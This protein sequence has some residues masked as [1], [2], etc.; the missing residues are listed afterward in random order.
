MTKLDELKACYPEATTFKFG[1]SPDLSDCLLSLV[2]SGKK[3]AT[4]EV[5]A[6]FESGKAAMPQVG[7]HDIAL[8]WDDRPALVIRT[9]SLERRRFCDVPESFALAEGESDSLEAWRRDHEEYFTRNGG[10]DPNMLL[11]CERFEL[12]EDLA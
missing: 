2:R 5:L 7:R 11:I 3:T 1:D 4:C 8:E 6:T 12:V 9:L 10:F